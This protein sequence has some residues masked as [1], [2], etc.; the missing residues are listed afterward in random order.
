M[1]LRLQFPVCYMKERLQYT[2]PL[3]LIP[4]YDYFRKYCINIDEALVG[5]RN[6]ARCAQSFFSDAFIYFSKSMS[7]VN[8]L[9][10]FVG[11]CIQYLL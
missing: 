10:N 9:I 1:I 6:L 3:N 11:C 2:T 7:V 8:F 5:L 4:Y